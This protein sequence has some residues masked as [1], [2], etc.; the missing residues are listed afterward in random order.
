MIEQ[1]PKDLLQKW[2]NAD[3]TCG[4]GGHYKA[5][6]N[7]SLREQYAMQLREFGIKVP[8]N[9]DEWLKHKQGL[10]EINTEL[11][12]GVFNGIGTY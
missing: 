6:Q 3:A 5:E 7:E 12:K 1:E 2:A 10:F 9:F 11:P 4:C 8:K